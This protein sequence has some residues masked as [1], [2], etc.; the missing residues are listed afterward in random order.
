MAVKSKKSTAIAR[1]E[2]SALADQLDWDDV[3]GRLLANIARG[4][5]S[6]QGVLREYVQNA[7]DAYKDLET[8]T[9]E[10]KIIITPTKNSLS[11]QDFG[12]GMD[13]KGIREAKK[14]AVS[15]KSDYDDRVGFRGIGIWA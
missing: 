15:T 14:I 12:V 13:D 10:H 3:G 8:P 9:E 2:W 6:P 5:Y 4:M 7:A 1:D 11:I